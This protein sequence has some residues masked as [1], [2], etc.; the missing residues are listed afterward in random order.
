M[1]IPSLSY[2][3]LVRTVSQLRQS[4]LAV[5]EPKPLPLGPAQ[6][7]LMS[8]LLMSP[9]SL[10]L[11]HPGQE[12]QPR[13]KREILGG[14]SSTGWGERA[15]RSSV[16]PKHLGTAGPRVTSQL[17]DLE[18]DWSPRSALLGNWTRHEIRRSK[19]H[20]VMFFSQLEL[21]TVNSDTQ[22]GLGYACTSASHK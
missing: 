7:L 2:L 1:P 13:G 11:S 18:E 9:L 16:T 21:G 22:R 4:W 6:S 12:N 3:Q 8:P 5:I 17:W 14:P 10:T 15:F 19:F 20:S